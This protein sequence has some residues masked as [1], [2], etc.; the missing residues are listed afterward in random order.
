[1]ILSAGFA[2]PAEKTYEIFRPLFA[3]LSAVP[4]LTG[5]CVD[6]IIIEVIRY[7]TMHGTAKSGG[8]LNGYRKKSQRTSSKE[9]NDASP[10]GRRPNHAEYAFPD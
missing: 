8:R 5:A 1:M 10:A 4:L 9:K 3:D 2:R 7:G 6:D